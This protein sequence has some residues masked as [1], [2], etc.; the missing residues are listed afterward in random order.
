VEDITR[1]GGTTFN[2]L[3]TPS[4]TQSA[5]ARAATTGRAASSAAMEQS[6]QAVR[7][8]SISAEVAGHLQTPVLHLSGNDIALVNT[9]ATAGIGIGIVFSPRDESGTV[10]V[11]ANRVM[12][13]DLRTSAAAILFPAIAAVTGN[14]LVQSGTKSATTA[15]AFVL[16]AEASARLEVMA[17]VIHANAVILPARSNSGATTSWN[18]VNTVS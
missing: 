12:T 18:F 2:T 3:G 9:A 13:S 14:V 8:I 1:R 15:A 7:E 4:G 10:L 16:L 11:T 6:L 5:R 17:N